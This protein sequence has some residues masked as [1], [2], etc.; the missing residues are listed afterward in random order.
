MSAKCARPS[1]EAAYPAGWFPGS[2]GRKDLFT[3]ARATVAS[4]A[5]P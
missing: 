2:V 4:A 5:R 1:A 3:L